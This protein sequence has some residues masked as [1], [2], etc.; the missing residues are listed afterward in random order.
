[1]IKREKARKLPGPI[2][3]ALQEM[4]IRGAIKGWQDCAMRYTEE[5]SRARGNLLQS[6][7]ET[8]FGRFEKSGLFTQVWYDPLFRLDLMVGK[9]LT[10][11]F[12]NCLLN[13]LL[14]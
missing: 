13:L 4:L 12:G 6:L 9:L 5:V 2:S 1:M 8:H 14:P 11:F 7:C 3:A 10:K